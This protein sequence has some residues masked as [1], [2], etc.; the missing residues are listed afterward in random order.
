MSNRVVIRNST[1]AR[2]LYRVSGEETV[3]LLELTK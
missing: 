3:V 2:G 1:G